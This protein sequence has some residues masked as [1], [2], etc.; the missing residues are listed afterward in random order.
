MFFFFA[1]MAVNSIAYAMNNHDMIEEKI[2]EEYNEDT[3]IKRITYKRSTT[4]AS[5]IVG[6]EEYTGAVEEGV[7]SPDAAQ[8]QFELLKKCYTYNRQRVL[9]NC[10]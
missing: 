3:V 8:K 7:L 10:Y 5:N 1:L 4:V 9:T 2:H 6:T